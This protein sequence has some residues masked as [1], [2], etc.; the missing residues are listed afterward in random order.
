MKI[1]KEK[2]LLYSKKD[3]REKIEVLGRI[4]GKELI[5]ERLGKIAA[6]DLTVGHRDRIVEIG[7]KASVATAV[8]DHKGKEEKDRKDSVGI[9]RR[10]SAV[11]D[12]RISVETDHKVNVVIDRKVRGMTDA[13][14]GLPINR[15]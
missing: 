4:A 1:Q 5:T 3:R 10:V 12:R 14:T 11:I 13:V 7:R 2:N 15:N 8:I 6:I 9:D